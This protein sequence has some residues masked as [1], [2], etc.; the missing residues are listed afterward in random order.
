MTS[1]T[2]KFIIDAENRT[3]KA[4]RDVQRGLEDVR[5][6]AEKLQ[7]AFKKIAIAGTAAFGAITAGAIL[8]VNAAAENEGAWNKFNTVFG[9]HAGDMADFVKDI[10]TRL[11]SATTDIVKMSSGIQD[12]LIPMGFAR[13][14][15][16]GMTKETL[17]LANALSAFN[18]VPV[19]Q[20]LDAMIS[21]FSGMTRPLKQFG[22]DVPI[23]RLQQMAIEAGI[24]EKNLNELD[25]ETQR[26][27][28][29]QLMLKAA[30]E[31]SGDA[32]AGFEVNQD[33]YIRR[34]QEMKASIS[35]LTKDIGYTLL[36]IFDD[37]LKKILPI[38]SS[39]SDW[40]K[41]NQELT[42]VIIIVSG[43][44]AGLLAV[45]GFIGLM[46]PSIITGFLFLTG[47]IGLVIASVMALVLAGTILIT[48]W[49]KVKS[50]LAWI[51]ET[52]RDII[53]ERWTEIQDFF[54]NIWDSIVEIFKSSIEWIEN[55]L[56]SIL[57]IVDRVKSA[58]S[59]IS[60]FFSGIK[61]GV[62][63]TLGGKQFGGEI[64]RT[65]NYLLHKGESVIPSKKASL[66]GGVTININGGYFLSENVAEEIGDQIINKLKR[67]TKL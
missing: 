27:V 39:I 28:K 13:D 6:K 4:L 40:I 42:K 49:D 21:G 24:V 23:E 31:D 47:P 16:M 61:E 37:I 48:K 12:L 29:A 50:G 44:L 45:I 8:S 14:E 19:E 15:A 3:D 38:I 34:M 51:W 67:I 22:I 41:E 33:S 36:P 10:R 62:A 52:M 65:G 63:R 9:E 18:D 56:N 11:P 25:F 57:D 64:Q 30:Y 5:S 46:L 2:L 17:E 58:G 32:L 43:A 20:V 53:I 7:P 60:G 54:K 35:D 66:S 59:K 55:K 26:T 1:E